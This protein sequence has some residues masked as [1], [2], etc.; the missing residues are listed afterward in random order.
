MKKIFSFIMITLVFLACSSDDESTPDPVDPSA[1]LIGTWQI[2]AY[3]IDNPYDLNLDGT[4][5][6]NVLLEANCLST[7]KIVFNENNTGVTI[8]ESSLVFSFPGINGNPYMLSCRPENVR[9]DMIWGLDGSALTFSVGVREGT[10]VNDQIIL[11][12]SADGLYKFVPGYIPGGILTAV[13]E[14][15]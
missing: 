2:S 9:V 14:K 1:K 12:Y 11:M 13:F 3:T 8:N 5:T 15:L 10:Y 6:T 4:A 7:D